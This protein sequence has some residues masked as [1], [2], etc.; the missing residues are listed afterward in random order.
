MQ[1]RGYEVDVI[2][3]APAVP[4]N[5]RIGAGGVVLTGH[6]A[7]TNLYAQS[8]SMHLGHAVEKGLFERRQASDL[9]Q[10]F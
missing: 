7:G 1:V 5:G 6:S 9:V 3:F 10:R 4:R 8:G 2:P